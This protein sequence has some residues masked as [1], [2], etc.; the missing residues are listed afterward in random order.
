MGIQMR[1]LSQT[2]EGL[3]DRSQVLA[4]MRQTTL[5]RRLLRRPQNMGKN[6]V[7]LETGKCVDQGP[8]LPCL[9]LPYEELLGLFHGPE[10]KHLYTTF[11]NGD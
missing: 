3:E 6:R 11:L 1:P 7:S 5:V 10:V 9:E 4:A 2:C 8:E